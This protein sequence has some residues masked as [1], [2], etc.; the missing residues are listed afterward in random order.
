MACQSCMRV[1]PAQLGNPTR[2]NHRH[3]NSHCAH[4]QLLPAPSTLLPPLSAHRFNHEFLH[5]VI[6]SY[7]T[8]RLM[9]ARLG[10]LGHGQ[11]FNIPVLA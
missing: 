3:R 5:T 6:L 10:G 2:F 8:D 4:S 9:R 1:D 11:A 7:A